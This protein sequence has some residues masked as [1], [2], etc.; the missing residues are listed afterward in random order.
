MASGV[1]LQFLLTEGERY[2]TS[3]RLGDR[4]TNLGG[5]QGAAGKARVAKA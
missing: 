1:L 5:T 3:G 4:F 2:P